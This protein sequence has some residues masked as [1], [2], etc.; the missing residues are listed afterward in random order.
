M[1]QVFDGHISR[2]Y[3][4]LSAALPQA[5]S[6][7]LMDKHYILAEIKRTAAAN[8]GKALGRNRFEKET[9]IRRNDWFGKH[10]AR[11]SDAVED[12]GLAA[13]ALQAAYELEYVIECL[14]EQIRHSGRYPTLAEIALYARD[15]PGTP[16][17]AVFKN[18]G[19]KPGLAAKVVEYCSAK[20]GYDDVIGICKPIAE[21]RHAK[22]VE[23]TSGEDSFGHVY[24]MKSGKF[25]KIGHS[26]AAGRREYELSIQ[27]PEKLETIHII[28]TD[29]PRGI[30]AYWHRR[31]ESKRM[32]GEWFNL[33]PADLQAFKRRKFM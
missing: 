27:L 23:P 5:A 22:P 4:I 2:G 24:L 8:G 28:A 29:D 6:I 10:W 14:I 11:W 16:S 9:G 21:N 32:N 13:N 20:E 33:D 7:G 12:A 18:F 17:H 1:H 26:N 30:E 3:A 25:Y 19:G 31:F 15:H